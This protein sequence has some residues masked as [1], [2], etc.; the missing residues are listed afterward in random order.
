MI[1]AL[2][3]CGNRIM[4]SR[5]QK[6]GTFYCQGCG[7]DLILKRGKI[8]HAHFS[9]KSGAIC[10]F[11]TNKTEWHYEWQ[12]CFGEEN[13]EK[14]FQIAGYKHIAD[15]QIGDKII[16]FQH[17][18][19]SNEDVAERCQFYKSFG[20]DV[21]WIFD[22]QK[23]VEERKLWCYEKRKGLNWLYEW[24]R[25][26]GAVLRALDMGATV[27]LQADKKYLVKITWY[28]NGE[29]TYPDYA[30]GDHWSRLKKFAATIMTKE[31]VIAE[32]I[33][34]AH[35]NFIPELIYPD[36]LASEYIDMVRAGII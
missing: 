16:E 22:A 12:K 19:I 31:Q 20:F 18:N 2:D 8:R 28:P 24:A 14:V 21:V 36:D 35:K 1:V 27:Y 7:E 6:G 15:I 25:P 29:K 3:E 17:S 32:I 4:A 13:A 33:N 30:K 26:N 34:K 10:S 9:H 5:A 11:I 23:E